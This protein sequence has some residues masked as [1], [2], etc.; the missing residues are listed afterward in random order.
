MDYTKLTKL[1]IVWNIFQLLVGIMM[2]A[3]GVFPAFYVYVIHNEPLDEP[4]GPS[5]PI[6][7]AVHLV[8]ICIWGALVVTTLT[9][10]SV[11]TQAIMRFVK[12]SREE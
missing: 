10:I 1:K 7:T 4:L 12:R 3:A 9:G 2:I 8:I 5:E 11:T 6:T